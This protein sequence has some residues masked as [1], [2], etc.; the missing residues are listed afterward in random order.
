MIFFGSQFHSRLLAM[1]APSLSDLNLELDE[2][3]TAGT[4]RGGYHR[5]SSERDGSLSA[6]QSECTGRCG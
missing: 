4:S 6:R 2:A 5:F 3:C 1:A